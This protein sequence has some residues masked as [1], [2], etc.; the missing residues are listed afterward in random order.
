MRGERMAEIR[1]REVVKDTKLKRARRQVAVL[2]E[3]LKILE[4]APAS[5]RL[6]II[7][8]AAELHGI[9]PD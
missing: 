9:K 7:R 5:K 4:S 2:S 3:V 1:Q 8:A 6:R